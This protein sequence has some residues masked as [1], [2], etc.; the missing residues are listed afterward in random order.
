MQLPN[1][2]SGKKKSENG[3]YANVEFAAVGE[4]VPAAQNRPKQKPAAK[5]NAFVPLVTKTQELST[6]IASRESQVSA[7][8]AEIVFAGGALRIFR[9]IDR[10]ALHEILSVLREVSR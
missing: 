7:P 9:N 10:H 8:I 1:E 4:A 2:R 6:D 5:M 3:K